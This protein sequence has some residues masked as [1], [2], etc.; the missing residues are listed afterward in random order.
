MV[1][2][3]VYVYIHVLFMVGIVL[4]ILFASSMV[5][6]L[7]PYKIPLIFVSGM[8]AGTCNV[9]HNYHCSLIKA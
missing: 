2:R 3:F 5:L 4:F 6:A 9:L 1:P 7:K 8:E